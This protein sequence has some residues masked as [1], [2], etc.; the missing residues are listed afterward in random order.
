MVRVDPDTKEDVYTTCYFNSN[1]IVRKD[2]I[3][4]E[5]TGYPQKTERWIFSTLHSKSGIFLT[6]LDKA[7][8][9]EENDTKIITFGS[10]LFI[11]RPF[12][13]M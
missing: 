11:L 2:I 8:S 4:E 5:Y 13:E 10:V 9:A 12:L 7:S 1:L 3:D 6:S